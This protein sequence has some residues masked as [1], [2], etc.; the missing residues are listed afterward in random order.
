[1]NVTL[2]LLLN[3]FWISIVGS[4]YY[5]TQRITQVVKGPLH[6]EIEISR[7]F[8]NYFRSIKRPTMVYIS[9][10]GQLIVLFEE[11]ELI[12]CNLQGLDIWWSILSNQLF[13]RSTSENHTQNKMLTIMVSMKTIS[14]LE[15]DVVYM[16]GVEFVLVAGRLD[17][18][19]SHSGKILPQTRK[20]MLEEDLNHLEMG[21]SCNSLS[22]HGDK[23]LSLWLE[24]KR[25]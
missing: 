12:N 8:Y 10:L 21:G 24:W 2:N 13:Y 4:L 11:W 6:I 16:M 3:I 15:T 20:P 22:M 7:C 1:M 5:H 14:S 25:W 19:K 9:C 23:V 18:D 17:G